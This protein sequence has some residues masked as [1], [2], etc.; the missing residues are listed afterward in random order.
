[1]NGT[2]ARRSTP[3]DV[4]DNICAIATEYSTVLT[5]DWRALRPV[6][7]RDRCVKCATCWLYCPV[8]CMV[9]RATWFEANL[10]T[11]KGCG[12]CAE[13]CPHRAIAMIEEAEG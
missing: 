11:C 9:E 13:E 1:M 3:Q 10:A 2:R 7:D 4:S 5:G 6:V 12:I 8:Q